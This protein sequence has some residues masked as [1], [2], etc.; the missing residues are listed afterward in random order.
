MEELYNDLDE[1]L[2]HNDSTVEQELGEI[3]YAI[4]DDEDELN[5]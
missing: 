2:S 3:F 5:G 4:K 1:L